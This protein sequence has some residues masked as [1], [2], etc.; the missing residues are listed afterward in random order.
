MAVPEI[1]DTDP[2]HTGCRSTSIHFMMEKVL[3]N[4]EYPLVIFDP[5][6]YLQELFDLLDQEIWQPDA[7]R[8]RNSGNGKGA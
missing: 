7:Q 1:M 4:G 2:L 8:G 5:I 6:E 3:R